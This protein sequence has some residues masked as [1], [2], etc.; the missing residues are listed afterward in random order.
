MM[1]LASSHVALAFIVVS[2]ISVLRLW[3]FGSPLV[4]DPNSICRKTRRMGGGQ[5]ELCQSQPELIQEVTRGAKL[6]MRECQHQLRNHLWNCSSQGKLLDAILRQDI[7]ETALV[8]A[9]TAAG[10][11]HAVTH[12][13]SMGDLLQCGCASN[14]PS[15]GSQTPSAA[16]GGHWE[17]GGCGD[18]V[19]FG[20][21]VSRQATNLRRSGHSDIR[22]LINLHNNEAGRLAVLSFMRVDCKC[23]GLSGSCSL[24][25]CWRKMPPFRETGDWLL[26]RY[27]VA[28]QVM[29]TNDGKSI[30]P[31]RA[32]APPPNLHDLI[33]SAESP[34]FCLASVKLGSEGTQNRVCDSSD[35]GFGGCEW[36]CCGRGHR[37][38][39]IILEE[40]CMCQFNW[41]C[42]VH[43]ERCSLT[44]HINICL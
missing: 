1:L 7:R 23:H 19:G 30:V 31:V 8:Y 15:G 16:A 2:P 25:S 22:T 43:C 24:R 11:V 39:M 37:K 38:Y 29:G 12:A 14:P 4:M 35:K 27:Q 13:C 40:N 18:D 6:G 17:W 34:D 21:E 33:Y 3:V 5:S 9:V 28:L 36:L 20:Y 32:V 44:R 42:E 10:V 41:C 26:Q